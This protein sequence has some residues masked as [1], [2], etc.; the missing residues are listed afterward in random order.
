M[1]I[2]LTK[3]ILLFENCQLV[4]G[5]AQTLLV[6]FQRRNLEFLENTIFDIFISKNRDKN[7]GEILNDF[8]F[9]TQR[10]ILEYFD[11]LLENEYA[12]LCDKSEVEFFPKI[13]SEWNNPADITNCI[14]DFKEKPNSLQAYKNLIFDLDS[15]GCENIQIRVFNDI[16]IEFVEEFLSLFE[17]TIIFRI[18]LLLK[19]SQNVTFYKKFIDKFPRI[20]ELIVHSARINKFYNIQHQRMIFL[21]KE[22]KDESCCGIIS[23][24]HFNLRLEHFLESQQYNTCLNRKVCIDV[25]GNI[26]NCSALKN[27]FGNISVVRIVEVVNTEEF[28]KIWQ[29]SKNK[30]KTCQDCEFRHICTDCRAFLHSD[31]S[32]DKPQ[33]CNYFPYENELL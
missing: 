30:I 19:C 15:L 8:D 28:Q 10:N 9:E 20:K 2:D 24:N 32:L 16:S 21:E 14:I 18:D 27:S 25:K 12:F 1:Q 11:F 7:I 33:K 23:P 31:Y 3:H 13:N 22:I 4:K 5:M 29:I 17:N 6:D 26:K